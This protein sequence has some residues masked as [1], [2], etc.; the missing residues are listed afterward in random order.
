MSGLISSRAWEKIW[1]Y[2]ETFLLGLSNTLKTAAVALLIRAYMGTS[3]D[4]A[5]WL[6]NNLPQVDFKSIREKLGRQPIAEI[7]KAQ[8]YVLER[9]NS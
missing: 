1:I 4:N 7:E 9:L 2:R 6:E 3:P 8:N 5:V